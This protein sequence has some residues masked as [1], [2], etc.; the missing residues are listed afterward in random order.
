VTIEATLTRH[1]VIDR[2]EVEKTQSAEGAVLG[3]RVSGKFPDKQ[4]KYRK[5]CSV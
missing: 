5:F 2:G 3:E 4:G 1:A